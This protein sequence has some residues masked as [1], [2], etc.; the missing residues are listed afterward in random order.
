MSSSLRVAVLGL[1][2][3]GSIRAQILHEMPRVDLV[4]CCDPNESAVQRVPQGVG[5]ATDFDEVLSAGIDALVV[6]TPDGLHR[7]ATVR[8]LRGGVDVFCEKPLATT[9][10]D[11]DAMIAAEQESGRR[12][13]VGHTLRA[14]PRYRALRAKVASGELGDAVHSTSRR[15]WPAPEGQ[16]QCGQTTLAQYLSV[17]ELDILQWVLNQPI[18][19]VY[20]EASATA[21]PG[22]RG[23]S[24]SLAA[25][26]RFADGSIGLHECSWGLPDQAGLSLGD[27]ALSYV[28]TKGSVYLEEREQ[29]VVAYGGASGVPQP[30]ATGLDDY[31]LRGAIEYLAPDTG[32]VGLLGTAY[33]AEMFAFV[34]TCLDGA[35]PLTSSADGRAALAA[36]LA[37]ELSIATGQPCAVDRSVAAIGA[38]AL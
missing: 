20:G 25:T 1:G 37:L 3:M 14:D 23:E 16:R 11:A 33:G 10:E 6:A 19:N 21:L 18:V 4:F 15:S 9:L 38:G 30:A 7:D 27:C 22:F 36:V 35:P 24:P 32:L 12:L 2:W 5:F 13:V 28:G 26:L 34:R 17:H 29:G 31:Q 8:A